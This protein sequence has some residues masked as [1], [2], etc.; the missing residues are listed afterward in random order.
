MNTFSK[1]DLEGLIKLPMPVINI[2]VEMA[3]AIEERDMEKLQSVMRSS[4][5]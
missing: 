1:Y 4:M 5:N 2:L 3:N